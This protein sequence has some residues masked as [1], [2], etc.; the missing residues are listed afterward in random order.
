M[1]VSFTKVD[2]SR[3]EGKT[4]KEWFFG[5]FRNLYLKL[6]FHFKCHKFVSSFSCLSILPAL[7]EE[8]KITESMSPKKYIMN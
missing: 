6:L 5:V 7:K 1:T 2:D 8:E 3:E 4:G